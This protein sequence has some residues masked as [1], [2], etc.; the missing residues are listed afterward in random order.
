MKKEIFNGRYVIYSDG[1]I[2]SVKRNKF[3]KLTKHPKGYLR[4]VISK[5]SYLVHQLVA[6]TFITNHDNL[7][8][9]NHINEI[10]DDNRV[11]NL[12][13]CTTRYNVQ[14]KQH[15]EHLGVRYH[16]QNDTYQARVWYDK[17]SHSLGYFKTPEEAHTVYIEYIRLH[18]L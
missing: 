14:H 7:P 11:E 4:I 15:K 12:E 2:W 16:K 6:Q 3:L 8:E 18:N 1:R 5:K 9:V 10:K 13:W 17:K